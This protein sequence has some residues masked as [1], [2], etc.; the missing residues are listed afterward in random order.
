MVIRIVYEA[1]SLGLSLQIPKCSFFPRHT[2]KTLGTIAD[3]TTFTFQESRSRENKVKSTICELKQAI[4]TNPRKI[5]ARLVASFI[6]LIWS[7]STC[8]H[9]AA[10]V[11][12]RSIVALLVAK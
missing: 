1:V 4:S 10:S 7:I 6:G 3:L 2:I 5:P 9:R 12:L 8:C 11:M